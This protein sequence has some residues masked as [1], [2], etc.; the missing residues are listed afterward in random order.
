MGRIY[1]YYQDRIQGKNG[2]NF[3]QE[4]TVPWTNLPQ[5][6][7]PRPPGAVCVLFFL[8]KV[9]STN[10]TFLIK[11]SVFKEKHT[12]WKNLSSQ[13][14]KPS[15]TNICIGRFTKKSWCSGTSCPRPERGRRPSD[16]S[17]W[18]LLPSYTN[19]CMG[20]FTKTVSS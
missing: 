17:K 11:Q 7:R 20:R 8:R 10:S 6:S 4:P 18:S 12:S 15:Y 1:M 5:K 2:I 19:I 14:G 3:I 9:H 13:I 16:L